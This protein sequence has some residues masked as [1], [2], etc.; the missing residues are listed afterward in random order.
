MNEDISTAGGVQKKRKRKYKISLACESC[1]ARKVRCDGLQPSCTMCLNRG[2]SCVFAQRTPKIRLELSYVQRLEERLMALE[3]HNDYTVRNS[4]GTVERRHKITVE[5]QRHKQTQSSDPSLPPT[6]ERLDNINSKE[7]AYDSSRGG[8]IQS[9][10]ESKQTNN[11]SPD[12]MGTAAYKEGD[13]EDFFGSSSAASFIRTVEQAVDPTNKD[14]VTQTRTPGSLDG[15]YKME[16][17]AMQRFRAGRMDSE[18]LTL[19]ARRL[20]DTYIESYFTFVYSLYPFLHKPS[21]LLVYEEIWKPG[22]VDTTEDPLFYCILNLV[23]ALGC[24][25][26]PNGDYRNN[27]TAEQ[28]YCRS[29]K[30]M[31]F[32]YLSSGSLMLIQA[33]LLMGQYLQATHSPTECWNI[34]GLAIR[35]AQGL[36]L[37]HESRILQRR[38]II[39]QQLSRRL[40]FGCVVMDRMVSMTFGRPLMIP[41]EFDINLPAAVDD[42]YI[43]DS[44]IGEQPSA[45]PSIQMFFIETIKLYDILAPILIQVYRLQGHSRFESATESSE[46]A[47]QD[48]LRIDSHLRNYKK[49]INEVLQIE[50][51]GK[52][53]A[54]SI[55]R[56]QTNILEIR[57]LHIRIMLYRPL[58][59]P[60]TN[61]HDSTCVGRAATQYGH[62]STLFQS[63]IERT[64]SKLCV[65]SAIDLINLIYENNNTTNVP[66]F[67]YIIYFIYNSAIVL[68]AGKINRYIKEESYEEPMARS[69]TM[70]LKLL[71]DLQMNTNS[72]VRCLQILEL[73]HEKISRRASSQVANFENLPNVTDVDDLLEGWNED[74]NT[75]FSGIDPDESLED[76][77]FSGY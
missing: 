41:Y 65:D 36:G 66:S 64:A 73:A 23:F 30:I 25:L 15:P 43:S 9:P 51:V 40:W 67:W 69:W 8:H 12:G 62:D 68:L 77:L 49:S 70:A 10:D 48:I 55:L 50:N 54:N 39:E 33:L 22:R 29:R 42:S 31:K 47:W 45:E 18:D 5:S 61:A 76:M 26:M 32:E 75:L 53:K 63:S 28:Y 58:L 3:D 27:K 44:I 38:N 71:R 1:R 14:D 37:H 6:E 35:V 2:I 57:Y 7:S 56:R 46:S 72:A 24:L 52:H 34:V 16:L 21:F 17:D 74:L 4:L 20:A 11:V 19:P 13:G 59:L 60:Y